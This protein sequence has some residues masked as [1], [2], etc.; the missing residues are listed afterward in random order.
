MM[1][2]IISP[3][4]VVQSSP[5]Q[6]STSSFNT[7]SPCALVYEAVDDGFNTAVDAARV[8]AQPGLM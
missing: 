1:L 2:S 7:K 4:R 3:Q 5:G 8:A 6:N